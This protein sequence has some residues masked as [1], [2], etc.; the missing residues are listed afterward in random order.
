M[1]TLLRRAPRADNT[2][3]V[4]YD[5]LDRLQHPFAYPCT[6]GVTVVFGAFLLLGY[7]TV[8]VLGRAQAE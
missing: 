4:F 5:I 7:A 2:H 3:S 1:P 6:W 8:R